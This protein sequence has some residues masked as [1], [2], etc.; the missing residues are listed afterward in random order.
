MANY[1]YRCRPGYGSE[2]LLIEFT[3]EVEKPNFLTDLFD[4]IKEI[5]PVISNKES[6]L[7]N[8]EISYT[9]KIDSGQFSLVID[10]WNLAFLMSDNQECIFKINRLLVEDERFEKIEVNF[11]DYKTPD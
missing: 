2:E 6:I 3:S 7:L 5:N 1:N 8:G 10:S 4:A 11:D 9:I